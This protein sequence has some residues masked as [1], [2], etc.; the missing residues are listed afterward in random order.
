MTDLTTSPTLG[1]ARAGGPLSAAVP[2]HA[3]GFDRVLEFA[4]GSHAVALRNIPGTHAWFSTHFPRRPV[5]PGVLLLQDM[6]E[7]ACLVCGDD[8]RHW[9]L[10]SVRTV[11]FRHFVGPGDQVELTVHVTGR[12][13]GSCDVRA[14]ARVEGRT[15]ATARRL[16]LTPRE[17][18]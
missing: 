12:T 18:S 4:P 3:H 7:L 13:A 1:S 2:G 14:E 16:V 17:A 8:L 9:R 11:R 6:A 10:S 15:V 5:L